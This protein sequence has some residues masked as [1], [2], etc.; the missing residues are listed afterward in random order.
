MK[1]IKMCKEHPN[2]SLEACVW[3]KGKPSVRNRL[4]NGTNKNFL[5]E[6]ERKSIEL[7][8]GVPV[9]DMDDAKRIMKE[10]D[11][12][13]APP[14]KDGGRTPKSGQR[15]FQAPK[16]DIRELHRKIRGEMNG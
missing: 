14:T 4:V 8:L 9:R 2:W 10:K 11:L 16:V 5:K 15:L 3:C 1:K 6:S 13:F 7:Q 12:S